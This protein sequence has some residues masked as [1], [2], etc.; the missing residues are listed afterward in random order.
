MPNRI[1]HFEIE[2]KDKAR[3]SK[4]YEEAFGWKM[5]VSG[6]DMG[7]YVVVT[8][9][10]PNDP[11][12]PGINGGIYEEDKKVLNA[13][14][15]VISVDDIDKAI[16]D[17]KAARSKIPEFDLAFDKTYF[18]N[19]YKNKEKLLLTARQE[20]TNVGFVVAYDRDKDGSLYCW[21]AGVIPQYRSQGAFGLLMKFMDKWAKENGYNKIKVKTHNNFRQMLMYLVK[22]G[23]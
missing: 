15:C 17:V 9:G 18:E 7:G 23:F 21:M 12:D 5:L 20:T 14:S 10:A 13:Y 2:A 4:F 8:T 16:A 19:R 1:V 11:K 3:A 6:P 22:N